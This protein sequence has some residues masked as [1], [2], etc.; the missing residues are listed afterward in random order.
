MDPVRVFIVDDSAQLT[1]VLSELIEERGDA[2]VCGTA[3]TARE[4]V[5]NILR[6]DPDVVI[7][8][9]QLRQGSGFDVIKAMRELDGADAPVRMR[10]RRLVVLFSNHM[11]PELRRRA[12]ELGA[13]HFLDKT[14]D[15]VRLIDLIHEWAGPRAH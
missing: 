3:D 14:S 7:A 15:H 8:D 10:G 6:D 5:D 12:L 11:A 13:D 9:L 1:E 2:I 4:A